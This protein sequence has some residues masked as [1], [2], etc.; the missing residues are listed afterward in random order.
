V[1]SH[2]LPP[3]AERDVVGNA[4]ALDVYKLL[5]LRLEGEEPVAAGPGAGAGRR[6]AG[7]FE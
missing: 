4:A 7:R 3:D 2:C 5:K 6:L 1:G